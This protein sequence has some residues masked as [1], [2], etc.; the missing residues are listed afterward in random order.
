M[1]KSELACL[2]SDGRSGATIN[3]IGGSVRVRARSRRA[4]VV[5]VG[6]RSIAVLRRALQ[7]ST[8]TLDEGKNERE[9]RIY[10]V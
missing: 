3:K 7:H 1:E 9:H 2:Y 5:S 6:G 4:A 8:D 10:A